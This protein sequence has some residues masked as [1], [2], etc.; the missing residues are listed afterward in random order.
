MN[1]K[2]IQEFTWAS[3]QI[4][5]SLKVYLI[6]WRNIC[7]DKYIF[8]IMGTFQVDVLKVQKYLVDE[9]DIFWEYS[10]IL[11]SILGEKI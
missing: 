1:V 4:Y 5:F 2:N 7:K 8:V 10:S 6:S 9:F 11:R 3:D